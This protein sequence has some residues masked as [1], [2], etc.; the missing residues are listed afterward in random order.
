LDLLS[1]E[2]GFR[3][4][5][6]SSLTVIGHLADG[7]EVSVNCAF[8]HASEL[9]VIAHSLV[10]F[11]VEVLRGFGWVVVVD[12]KRLLVEVRKKPTR[13]DASALA[14]RYNSRT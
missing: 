3:D 14:S 2:L 7:S 12:H 11:S 13:K 1:P 4:L 8:T 9:Q 6:G 10:E 5:I